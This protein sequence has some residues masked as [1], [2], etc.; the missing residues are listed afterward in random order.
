MSPSS[1]P[2]EFFT[3][4]ARVT[5]LIALSGLPFVGGSDFWL[6]LCAALFTTI[7]TLAT[8]KRAELL[9]VLIVLVS[10]LVTAFLISYQMRSIGPRLFALTCMWVILGSLLYRRAEPD[11]D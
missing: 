11:Q 1:R 9:K 8:E 7:V 5:S 2:S 3:F 10:G 6:L 4:K